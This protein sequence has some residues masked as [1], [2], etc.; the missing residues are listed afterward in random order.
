MKEKVKVRDEGR[1]TGDEK[2]KGGEE[3]KREEEKKILQ[4]AGESACVV[5]QFDKPT[6]K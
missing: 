6:L 3:G 4:P 5:R 2:G 1:K